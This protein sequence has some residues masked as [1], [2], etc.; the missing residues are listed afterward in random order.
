META[1]ERGDV[2]VF[3]LPTNTRIDYIKRVIGL[4]G[5]RIEMRGGRVVINGAAAA[6]GG[7]GI[8]D[9]GGSARADRC[10]GPRGGPHVRPARR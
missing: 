4:P 5:D 2:V 3:R 7:D 8:W 10:P 9:G 1:P 6:L